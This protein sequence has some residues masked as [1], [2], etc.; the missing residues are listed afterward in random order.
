[1]LDKRC[2]AIGPDDAQRV[3]SDSLSAAPPIAARKVGSQPRTSLTN[4]VTGRTTVAILSAAI[5]SNA[6]GGSAIVATRYLA[7]AVDAPTMGVARFGGGF[8]VLT[9]CIFWTRDKWPARSDWPKAAALG[10]CMF[11]LFPLLF[12]A[13]LAHTTAARGAL[14]LATVPMLTI[15]IAALLGIERPT[16]WRTLG[17]LV[18][19]G[20][21]A[22]SLGASL[23]SSPVGAWR[24]DVL[25]VAAG[26]CMACY[27]ILSRPFLDRSG[28]LPFT[29][30]CMGSGAVFLGTISALTGGMHDLV[31]L[32]GGQWLALFYLAAIGSAA[33]YFLL[34]YALGRTSPTLVGICIVIN[35]LTAG[36]LGIALL[37]EHA[38]PGFVLGVFAI[39]AGIA[40]AHVRTTS[41]ED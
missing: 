29:T 33:I 13:S 25:M 41:I 16:L 21:V 20:G 40:I 15:A 31:H 24:G 32:S 4:A 1:M 22:A 19:T 34:A 8:V 23:G 38:T 3:G 7:G 10:I 17:V 37:G 6:L 18:S 2:G 27:N 39:L 14:A 36:I 28:A 12:N 11:G 26:C 9:A 30:F 35:P 5:L